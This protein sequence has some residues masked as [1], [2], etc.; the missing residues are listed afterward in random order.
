MLTLSGCEGQALVGTGPTIDATV[1]DGGPR[2]ATVTDIPPTCATGLTLCGFECSELQGDNQHCGACDHVCG[3][4]LGCVAGA[5]VAVCRSVELLCGDRCIDPLTDAANCGACGHSC[6]ADSTCYSGTCEVVCQ[7]P[8]IACPRGADGMPVHGAERRCID[9]RNDPQNCA[10]CGIACTATERCVAGECAACGPGS[11]RCGTGEAQACVDLQSDPANCGACGHGCA[12]DPAGPLCFG[13][14]CVDHCPTGMTVCGSSCVDLQSDER[15]CGTCST[16]CDPGRVCARGLCRADCGA[17]WQDCDGVCRETRA[18]PAHCG[19]CAVACAPGQVCSRGTC[20]ATCA[21]GLVQCGRECRDPVRDPMACGGCQPPAGTGTLCTG[22]QLCVSS[23][24]R[25]LAG[26]SYCDTGDGT[27]P[28]LQCVDVTGDPANCGGC[29]R[30][31]AGDTACAAAMG[32]HCPPGARC[33]AGACVCPPEAPTSCP[34]GCCDLQ[35]DG[36]NC[37]VCG[38]VCPTGT[39]CTAGVCDVAPPSALVHPPSGAAMGTQRPAFRW[40]PAVGASSTVLEICRDRDC[41]FSVYTT[42][43]ADALA[44]LPVGMTLST[45][46]YYWRTRSRLGGGADAGPGLLGS[47]ASPSH[48]FFVGSRGAVPD[49]QIGQVLDVNGDGLADVAIGAPSSNEVHVYLGTTSGLTRTPVRLSGVSGSGYGTSVSPA[50][51][52]DGDGYGDLLVGATGE[53]RVYVIYGEPTG[54]GTRSAFAAGPLGIGFGAS[55]S[56]AGDTDGDGFG[57]VI[58]GATSA[59]Q[60]F[61]FRGS[62]A[63]LDPTARALG[64]PS[65]SG[66]PFYVAVAGAGDINADGFADILVGSASPSA[67]QV[68]LGSARGL[69]E[70]PITLSAPPGAAGFGVSLSGA[71]DVD[72]D[73][74]AD[75]LVGASGSNQAFVV[76]GSR[77]GPVTSPIALAAPATARSFGYAVAS[78]GDANA[79]GYG[80]LVI[81]AFGSRS[82]YLFNG[83]P[84]GPTTPPATLPTP[85]SGGLRFGSAVSGAGDVD[86]DGDAEI[87][88]GDWSASQVWYYPG[89]RA[90]TYT[91][92]AITGP[93]GSL[94]GWSVACAQPSP[95]PT[96]RTAS[97]GS[98]HPRNF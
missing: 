13:G 73:G 6:G 49:G 94:F 40:I 2:D 85:P 76:R 87:L 92:T 9:A 70:P 24:C 91:P 61:L 47:T 95:D 31:P 83:G 5:C 64:L 52:I 69:A 7:A 84:S 75:L 54:L 57:D 37:G 23:A 68:F 66:R 67:A 53:S 50:G 63:G 45:G 25:C 1:R 79:D 36:A 39:I 27:A 74:F 48:E 18:D 71:G 38:T 43:T 44:S 26:T 46:A 42:E 96:R 11:I 90:G 78:A 89:T 10:E 22:G 35:S 58:V 3:T 93:T 16:A 62:A 86:G 14:A 97:L 81:G 51:D 28:R 80:D 21:S 34:D 32:V 77:A 20:D 60:A 8:T 33:L 12:T 88:V 29:T 19:A 30:C 72:A 4:G 17:G 82:A 65:D 41:H 56:W 59:Q 55:V 98:L 15:H